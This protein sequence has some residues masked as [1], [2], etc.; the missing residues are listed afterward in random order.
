ME[1]IVDLSW[2]N[3]S[4]GGEYS[5]DGQ[6]LKAVDKSR[7]LWY[8]L[9]KF[10]TVN[11][12]TGLESIYEC[13]C[14]D[15]AENYGLSCLKYKCGKCSFKLD[16]KVYKSDYCVSE[17]Y[18]KGRETVS[19]ETAICISGFE[20]GEFIS[21]YGLHDYIMSLL[22][23]DYVVANRD[24]H[25]RNI[26]FF[27]V[28]DKFVPVPIF[29]NGMS[30]I[31]TPAKS[32]EMWFMGSHSF[33]FRINNNFMELKSTGNILNIEGILDNPFLKELSKDCITGVVNSY[34]GMLESW[35]RKMIVDF[36]YERQC[37][38]FGQIGKSGST[39]ME[40]LCS[41]S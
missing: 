36:V 10:N 27:M 35:M 13:I 32:K 11:G 22:Q 23:F 7:G 29:D 4:K 38:L 16:G 12:C 33:E 20:L 25:C 9:P 15:L 18:K 41:K 5:V 17:D 2:L 19:L 14:S 8:K 34:S 1:D 37:R 3:F 6:C 26:E 30:L 31:Q 24:R 40:R 39:Q 28:N 21:M